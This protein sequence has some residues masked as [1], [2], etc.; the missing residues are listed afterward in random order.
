MSTV[1]LTAGAQSTF[2]SLMTTELNSLASGNAI[3]G[4]TTIANATNNDLWIEFSFTTG[5]SITPSGS[6]FVAVYMYPLNGDT[7][8]YGDGRYGS[9]AAG[10]PP[11][12]YYRGYCGMGTSSGTQTG[13]FG[14]PFLGTFSPLPLGTFKPVFYNV[15]GVTLSASANILYYRTVDLSVA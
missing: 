3:I 13:T 1:K 7:T 12:N 14:V 10:P 5:G 2:T 8:T 11:S 4:T 9:A 15:T 6:P